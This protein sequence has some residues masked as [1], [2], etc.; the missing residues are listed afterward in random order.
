MLP[1]GVFFFLRSGAAGQGRVLAPRA[2][3]SCG[4]EQLGRAA[5]LRVGIHPLRAGAAGQGTQGS[6]QRRP[7]CAG[8]GRAAFFIRGEWLET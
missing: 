3:V 6:R 1:A 8:L 4:Q 7:G 5:C 2:F